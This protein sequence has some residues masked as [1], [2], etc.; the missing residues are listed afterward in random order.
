MMKR[1]KI[2]FKVANI[3]EDGRYGGPHSRIASVAEKLKDFGVETHVIFPSNKSDIF[4]TELKEKKIKAHP[5]K[6]NHISRSSLQLIRYLIYFIPDIVSLIKIFKKEK[7]NVVHCNGIAQIKGIIAAKVAHRKVIWHLN[8]TRENIIFSLFA[9]LFGRFLSDAFIFAAERIEKNYFSNHSFK[10]K[11]CFRIPA[12]VDTKR[13]NP[14][15][16]LSDCIEISEGGIAIISI[17]NV[18]PAKGFD[19]FIEMAHLL[20]KK[21]DVLK[22]YI[23]GRRYFQQ[24]R[25]Q[26]KL[27]S[28]IKKN[29]IKNL[30]FL[31]WVDDVRSILK[32]ADLYVCSSNHEASPMTVWEAMAMGKPIV[33][34]DAGDIAKFI[35]HGENGFV[36]P[37]GNSNIMAEKIDN[38]IMDKALREKFSRNARD[39]AIKYLDI[40]QCAQKHFKAYMTVYKN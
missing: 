17:G 30:F 40:D 8:D 26:Q 11:L 24:K 2:R 36:V 35:K 14:N 18:N 29:N 34:T 3:I 31:D 38:L 12:P 9:I 27:N 21:H 5:I 7:I 20:N 25:Y 32:K 16:V 10:K 33:A 28:M 1:H 22:F 15:I 23:V 6:L 4:Q 19:T 39:T 13:N 37:V